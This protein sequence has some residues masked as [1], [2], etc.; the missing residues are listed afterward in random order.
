MDSGLLIKTHAALVAKRL[1]LLT[2]LQDR[3]EIQIE[4]RSADPLD[5]ALA[6]S[7]RVTAVQ[8]INRN[9][10]LL[11]KVE[12]A[13]DRTIHGDLGV[14]V[15]CEEDIP[16]VRLSVVP[17]AERCVGCQENHERKI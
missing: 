17:W 3:S 8:T 11:R 16:P 12:A 10:A 14:C 13:L 1:E 15:S 4:G 2:S 6:A 5:E 7:A 9:M